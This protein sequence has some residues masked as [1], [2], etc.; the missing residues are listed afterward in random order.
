MDEDFLTLDQYP[1]A[2][3]KVESTFYV[4]KCLPDQVFKHSYRFQLLCEFEFA[5]SEVLNVFRKTRSPLASDTV[6]LSVLDPDPIAYFYKHFHRINA[7]YFKA[8]ITEDEYFDMRSRNPGNE[9]DAIQYNT[10]IET[11]VPSSLNWAMW[12]ERSSEIAVIGLDD[13]VLAK[14]LIADKGW[15][16]DAETSLQRFAKFPFVDQKVPEDFRRALI[17][18]YG[19]RADLEKKIGQNVDYPWEKQET[20]RRS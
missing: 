5:M 16:M 11:Y 15:W 18:N 3:Q 2:R 8:N 10:E 4:D 1:A 13:P 20:G 6:L 12:G 14:A 7:F 9:A 19:S 17:A